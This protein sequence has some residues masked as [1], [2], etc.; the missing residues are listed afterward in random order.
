L[1]ADAWLLLLMLLLLMMM[2]GNHGPAQTAFASRTAGGRGQSP[3]HCAAVC[4]RLPAIWS[5]LQVSCAAEQLRS[6]AAKH[7]ARLHLCRP[8][9]PCCRQRQHDVRLTLLTMPFQGCNV[10][11]LKLQ[12]PLYRVMTPIL[13]ACSSANKAAL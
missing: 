11:L 12:A 3:T 1:A 2:I 6:L 8:P 13:Y 10:R 4:S 9:M 5:G 7:L